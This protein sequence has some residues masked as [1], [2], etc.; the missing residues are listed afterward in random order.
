MKVVNLKTK[1][2][3]RQE[4]FGCTVKDFFTKEEC[5]TFIKLAEKKGF[6][7]IQKN[8][9]GEEFIDQDFR[10]DQGL[11][12]VNKKITDSIFEKVKEIVPTSTSVFKRIRFNKVS[13][14]KM[15]S[16][17]V[18]TV[19]EVGDEMSK[20]T[21]ILYLNDST[22]ITRLYNPSIMKKI[23]VTPKCGTVLIFDQRINHMGLSPIDTKY[24][25]RV[26]LMTKRTNL[27]NQVKITNLT[28][29]VKIKITKPKR[30]KPIKKNFETD[31]RSI[32]TKPVETKRS[33]RRFD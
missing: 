6:S 17:H 29:Q 33:F 1:E 13:P 5:E 10:T 31:L 26:D 2:K 32:L 24:I 15:C 19:I 22:G 9:F 30:T 16:G 12:M 23:D 25:M 28:N 21:I 8:K 20:W 27:T 3:L 7:D 18:D 4:Y 14:G 11:T